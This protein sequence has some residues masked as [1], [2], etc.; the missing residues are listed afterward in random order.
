VVTLTALAEPG[1]TFMGWG[2]ACSGIATCT[3]TMDVAKEVTAR[4]DWPTLSIGD[5]TIRE[6][7]SGTTK[8]MEFTVTLTAPVPP[9]GQ[10]AQSQDKAV[11]EKPKE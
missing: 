9:A 6:G 2:G 10:G 5:A 11:P 1:S 7:P 4:F 3:L 8:T